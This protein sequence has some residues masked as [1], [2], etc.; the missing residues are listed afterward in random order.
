M[1]DLGD[2][3]DLCWTEPIYRGPAPFPLISPPSACRH[4]LPPRY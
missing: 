4:D 2:G 3:V 1:Q